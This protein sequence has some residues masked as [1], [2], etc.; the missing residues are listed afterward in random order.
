M[1]PAASQYAD[2]VRGYDGSGGEFLIP[3]LF[4]IIV[5]VIFEFRGMKHGKF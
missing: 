3:L 1:I 2:K 4:T 5:A